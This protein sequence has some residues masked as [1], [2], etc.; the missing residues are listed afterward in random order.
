[1]SGSSP[2]QW[3]T[4]EGQRWKDP[5]EHRVLV[6]W[7]IAED[8]IEW[9]GLHMDDDEWRCAWRVPENQPMEY[10]FS[11]AA[12]SNSVRFQLTCL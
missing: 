10:Q 11:F 2:G 3:V 9:C 1:M 8:A 12:I 7:E 5:L 6:P 4:I